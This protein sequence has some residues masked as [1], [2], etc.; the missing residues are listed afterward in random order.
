MS[1]FFTQFPITGKVVACALE[2][3]AS[4]G[5]LW[6][7]SAIETLTSADDALLG[8]C[9]GKLS[10]VTGFLLPGTFVLRWK[11]RIRWS[12]CMRAL[13]GGRCSPLY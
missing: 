9:G 3:L 13:L 12:R 1:E 7:I 8:G 6:E 5:G 2:S 4:P 10:G 11:E